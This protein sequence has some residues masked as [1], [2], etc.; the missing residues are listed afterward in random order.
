MTIIMIIINVVAITITCHCHWSHHDHD[1][2]HDNH[3]CCCYHHHLIIVASR[4]DGTRSKL[5]QSHE[6]G[7][8][9]CQ[10]VSLHCPDTN[11]DFDTLACCYNTGPI[12]SKC[13][14]HDPSHIATRCP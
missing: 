9:T 2:D 11:G 12:S 5:D 1:Y 7:G 4:E 8:F 14:L 10:E 6:M 3:Q 13:F